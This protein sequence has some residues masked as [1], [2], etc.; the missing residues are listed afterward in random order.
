MGQN[1]SFARSAA[2]RGGDGAARRPYHGKHIPARRAALFDTVQGRITD[3]PSCYDAF[4]HFAG[5]IG[6]AKIATVVAV[7]E[8][9]VVKAEQSEDSRV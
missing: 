7:G 2:G 3:N 8:L 1:Q 4:D 6:K 9:L 5:N